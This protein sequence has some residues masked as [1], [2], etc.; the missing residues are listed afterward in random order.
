[1]TSERQAILEALQDADEP[2]SPTEIADATRMPNQNVR[3][4]LVSMV[5]ADAIRKAGRGRYVHPANA[6]HKEDP[7]HNDHN[8][9][10]EP[11][12]PE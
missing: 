4:L 5:K 7:H 2:M 8:I 12:G 3:Q 11:E 9:T 10:S 1:M 6:D